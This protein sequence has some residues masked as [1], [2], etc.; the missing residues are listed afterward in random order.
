VNQG[1]DVAARMIRARAA[2]EAKIDRERIGVE[3]SMNRRVLR[4]FESCG[5]K[6]VG[7][8][9]LGHLSRITLVFRDSEDK[10]HSEVTIEDKP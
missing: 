2:K 4:E 8:R 7:V 1:E 9:D 10:Y 3:G 6:L 5:F